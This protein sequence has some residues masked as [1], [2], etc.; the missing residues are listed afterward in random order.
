MKTKLSVRERFEKYVIRHGE[1]ECWGWAASKQFRGYGQLHYKTGM[2]T[3]HR[4]SYELFVGPIPKG[5]H[6]L[7]HC[8]NRECTNPAHLFLGTQKDNMDDR[9]SKNR[10]RHGE[11]HPYA[12]LTQGDVDE[13]RQLAATGMSHAEIANK[14]D[15]NTRHIGRIVRGERWGRSFSGANETTR[16]FLGGR[17]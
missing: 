13:I 17:N 15:S 3:A 8:D 16:F 14:Y 4:I 7:H 11:A 6:V 2:V 10:V 12:R 1:N 9:D 5:M